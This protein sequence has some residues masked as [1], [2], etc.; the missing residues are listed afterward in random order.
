MAR[1]KA[2]DTTMTGGA[3][4]WRWVRRNVVP[5]VVVIGVLAPIRSVIADWN[6][7]PSGSM[8][9]TIL[10]GDRIFVNKLAFG[11]RVPFTKV[12]V[13]QWDEPA[14]GDIV[15]LRSPDSGDRLVKR[16]VGVPGDRIAVRDGRLVI[17]GEPVRYE[18]APQSGAERLPD[19]R[20]VR[21]EVVTERL[22]GRSHAVAFT[23][24]LPSLPSLAEMTIPKDRYLVLGDNRDQSRD[25]RVF[26]FATR[27]DLY[28]RSGYVA[29]SV[30]PERGYMPRFDRWFMRLR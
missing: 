4:V 29:L 9:P 15:T 12:W 6:D 19:G 22:P 3:R 18:G 8:R 13:A 2:D 16:V 7:V 27:G 11:L 28:G 10:E 14:R 24:S 20:T 23:P 30:D 21:V 17:N 26:G 1:T 25:S 5:F